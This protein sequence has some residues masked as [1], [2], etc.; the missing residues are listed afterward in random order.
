MSLTTPRLMAHGPFESI[1]IDVTRNSAV[2]R[3]RNGQSVTTPSIFPTTDTPPVIARVLYT[4]ADRTLTVTTAAGERAELEIGSPGD[5]APRAGRRVVYLD[6][7]HWSAL[8]RHLDDPTALAPGEAA[9]ATRL[10][11]W[12]KARQ[13]ILPL[14][15]GHVIETTPM[16]GPKRHRQALAMLRLSRGWHMRDPV[17]VRRDEIL[18]AVGLTDPEPTARPDVFTLDP[19]TLYL[20]GET[21]AAS[22]DLPGY[23]GWLS[24]RLTTVTANFDLLIDPERIPPEKTTGWSDQ[25]ASIARDPAFLQLPTGQRR[26]AARVQA[27]HDVIAEPAVLLAL[28]GSGL[29]PEEAA[30]ALVEGLLERRDTMPFLRL[31]ADALGVRL[32]NPTAKWVPNDLIDMLYLGCATAYADAVAAER[33]AAQYLSAAWGDRSASC[34]VVAKLSEL[35]GLLESLGLV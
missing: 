25:M 33:A 21:P 26:T 24:Q 13:I 2:I 1:A 6:Q 34:P 5:D 23:F 32:L 11:A 8:A 19:D 14:S 16:F 35:V 7:C 31:H 4:Y 15:S 22:D 27:L 17:R 30:A 12:A 28:T 3:L 10:I 18:R 29:A 9:A 20:N